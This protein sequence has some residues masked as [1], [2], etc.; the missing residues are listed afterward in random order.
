MNI[1]IR[2]ILDVL[3]GKQID[4]G[5][6]APAILIGGQDLVSSKFIKLLKRHHGECVA[7]ERALFAPLTLDKWRE[8][9]EL[10]KSSQIYIVDTL[11]DDI[12]T[13]ELAKLDEVGAS[14]VALV[15][16]AS[17]SDALAKPEAIQLAPK[18]WMIRIPTVA[19][20]NEF[21]NELELQQNGEEQPE[22]NPTSFDDLAHAFS[23][24]YHLAD[25]VCEQAVAM[26]DDFVKGSVKLQT[27]K[28]QPQDPLALVR[29]QRFCTVRY[30]YK[31][32]PTSCVDGVSIA[33]LRMKLGNAVADQ[34]SSE[35]IDDIE[36]IVPV[37]N[38]G[39]YYAVG[40][41]EAIGKPYLP[42]VTKF[43]V[44]KRSF[45]IQDTDMRRRAL[46]D[47]ISVSADLVRGKRVAVV[48]EAIFTGATLKSLCEKL[49]AAKVQAIHIII[50]SPPNVTHCN[51]FV[52]PNRTLLLERYIESGLTHYFGSKSISFLNLSTFET[53]MSTELNKQDFCSKCFNR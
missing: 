45:E 23:N 24:G 47:N 51:A 13:V 9:F 30:L 11:S 46:V 49:H 8:F 14:R 6:V 29:Q 21:N 41:S 32:S 43:D 25:T 33:K 34:L 48:D 28:H 2:R 26:I 3:G 20:L 31:Y 52:Q 17:P 7:L 36:Y 10:F 12:E 53:L 37:P 35:V 27:T 22:R 4:M 18:F 39:V 15:R 5:A 1:E 19:G 38:S 50:P 16:I 40:V 42:S 44:S